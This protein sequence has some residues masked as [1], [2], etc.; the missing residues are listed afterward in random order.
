M[1]LGKYNGTKYLEEK[2]KGYD[3]ITL[4]QTEDD[5]AYLS[6]FSRTNKKAGVWDQIQAGRLP[7]RPIEPG[8]LP[9]YQRENSIK[10]NEDIDHNENH[11]GII[12]ESN[13]IQR[14][15]TENRF[16]LNEE[17]QS[18]RISEPNQR[19]SSQPSNIQKHP[20]KDLHP[21]FPAAAQMTTNP[22]ASYS[23]HTHS[24][25]SSSH[26]MGG[27]GPV[28]DSYAPVEATR[29]NGNVG[30]GAQQMNFTQEIPRPPTG[31]SQASNFSKRSR[32]SRA[33][34]VLNSLSQKSST[35]GFPAIGKGRNL[36]APSINSKISGS[37][38]S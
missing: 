5:V 8:Q 27:R 7:G 35:K 17:D 6:Q 10:N 25:R 30:L 12:H 31:S 32:L 28:F 9:V 18:N 38:R 14:Q 15:G 1:A 22:P 29:N 11:E 23:S 2:N 24:K 37:R 26:M 36:Y 16:E 20:E 34:S 3:N 13:K 21:T 4:H 19:P 33:S